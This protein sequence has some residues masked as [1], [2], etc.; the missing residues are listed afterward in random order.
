MQSSLFRS[1][2]ARFNAVP[3]PKVKLA[4]I[5]RAAGLEDNYS[6]VPVRAFFPEFFGGDRLCRCTLK[7][8]KNILNFQLELLGC[9]NVADPSS[10]MRKTAVSYPP[11]RQKNANLEAQA[12]P[13]E[14]RYHHIAVVVDA[15]A[16]HGF[17]P[18]PEP[19]ET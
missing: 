1:S 7:L 19:H 12:R 11:C 18:P 5:G 17:R 3:P 14:C 10:L 8:D 13:T 4:P 16:V 9:I 15:G 2:L 6:L